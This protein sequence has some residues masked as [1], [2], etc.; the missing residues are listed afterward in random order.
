VRGTVGTDRWAVPETQRSVGVSEPRGH[1]DGPALAV[2][3]PQYCYG[4]VADIALSRRSWT[5][6]E[7]RC[8]YLDPRK[9]TNLN[10]DLTRDDPGL[11]SP[12]E[13]LK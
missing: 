9:V 12:F 1:G 3:P 7:A 5:K 13:K 8:T 2:H 11:V 10:Q 4:R 6:T